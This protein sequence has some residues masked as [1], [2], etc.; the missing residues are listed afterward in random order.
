MIKIVALIRR[1]PQMTQEE[2]VHYWKTVHAP[3]VKKK[4][5]GL[6]KYIGS[7]PSGVTSA[8]EVVASDFD[9]VV[10][11]GFDSVKSMQ[12]A[13]SNP[14]FL[15]EDRRISSAKLMDLEKTR[16]MVVEEVVVPL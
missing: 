11:L 12:A 14:D 10:E 13:M 4:L 3:L 8:T 9:G 1:N 15:T 5:P 16:S 7:F 6:V 2:F